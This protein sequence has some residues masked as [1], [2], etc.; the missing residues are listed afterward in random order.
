MPTNITITRADIARAMCGRTIALKNGLE[1]APIVP[2]KGHELA[3]PKGWQTVTIN[4]VT[5]D[6]LVMHRW[7]PTEMLADVEWVNWALNAPDDAFKEEVDAILEE[8]LRG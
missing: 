5:E 4:S 1:L 3:A 2:R 6:R 8:N 7:I